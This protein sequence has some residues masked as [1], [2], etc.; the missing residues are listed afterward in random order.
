[1]EDGG[2]DREQAGAVFGPASSSGF[3]LAAFGGA[4]AGAGAGAADLDLAEDRGL[5]RASGG[6]GSGS[7]GGGGDWDRPERTEGGGGGGGGG[8]RGATEGRRWQ[9]A[10]AESAKPPPTIPWWETLL[11]NRVAV[12]VGAGI[13]ALVVLALLKPPIV[14]KTPE[15]ALEDAQLSIKYL[16]IWA[17]L[18]A[19]LTYVAPFAW[20]ALEGAIA[21][22]AQGS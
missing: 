3:A 2:G 14:Q 13:L 20:Q 6:I 7:R 11:Q 1:M 22:T 4:G 21:S 12:S 16:L 17:V 8:D 19:V 10:V 9:E 18:V 5:G 15:S